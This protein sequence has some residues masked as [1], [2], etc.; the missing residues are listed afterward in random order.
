[1]NRHFFLGIGQG[2]RSVDWLREQLTGVSFHIA[3]NYFQYKCERDLRE[4]GIAHVVNEL[5]GVRADYTLYAESQ[6]APAVMEALVR[7]RI[8]IPQNLVLLQ[9][10]GLNV[11]ALGSTSRQRRKEILNRSRT[12]WRQPSQSLTVPGNRWTAM[13]ISHQSVRYIH[14]LP[15]AFL[16]GSNQDCAD[17]LRQ[18][19][20]I[21]TIDIYACRDDSLF[22]YLEIAQTVG[23]IPVKLHELDG[24]HLNRAT[25][26]GLSQLQ[27][28]L[29][30]V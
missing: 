16:V 24:S 27:H 26:Q 14:N 20:K 2:Q 25:P 4:A 1:M 18:L 9:P 30:M 10:L 11:N 6:A 29:H 15:A 8:P 17:L 12:F 22:P 3:P 13:E 28:I 5:E 19:A 21:L 7:S 23:D